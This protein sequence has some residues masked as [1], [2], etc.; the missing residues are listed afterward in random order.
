MELLMVLIVVIA[1]MVL[2]DAAA[3]VRGTDSRDLIT[4]DHRR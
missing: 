3:L 1:G 4:D 2:F